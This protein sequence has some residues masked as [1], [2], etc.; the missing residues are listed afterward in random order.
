M[1]QRTRLTPRHARIPARRRPE[2]P[3]AATVPGQLS[4]R[5][6]TG[7]GSVSGPG[8]PQSVRELSPGDAALL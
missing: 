1:S 3:V 2:F 8:P 4:T 5:P 7:L 6:P